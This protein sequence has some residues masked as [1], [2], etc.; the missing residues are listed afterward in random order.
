[1]RSA[2]GLGPASKVIRP[3]YRWNSFRYG[4]VLSTCACLS[5]FLICL[6]YFRIVEPGWH[7]PYCDWLRTG[8][9]GVRF[10]AWKNCF[11]PNRPDRLWGPPSVLFNVYRVSLPVVKRPGREGII[12]QPLVPRLWVRGV[13][14]LLPLYVVI[15][16]DRDLYLFRRVSRLAKW[17]LALSYRSVHPSVRMKQLCSHRI[18]FREIL[19]LIIFQK[20]ILK[21]QVSLKSDKNNG[22]S[23]EDQYTFT[24]VSR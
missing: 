22:H 14:P 11:S 24:I 10:T 9:T 20:S 5:R 18:D 8:C 23:R 21:I 12:L 3:A 15:G 1:M 6:S 2:P 16:V 17:L 19:Y 7:I 4:I 13:I